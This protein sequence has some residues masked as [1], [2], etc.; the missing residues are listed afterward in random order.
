V[1]KQEHEVLAEIVSK[2]GRTYRFYS[3]GLFH[4]GIGL[5]HTPA[6]VQDILAGLPAVVEFFAHSDEYAQAVP[7]IEE[8]KGD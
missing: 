4:D 3:D 2:N 7:A 6:G 1:S 5:R 8:A